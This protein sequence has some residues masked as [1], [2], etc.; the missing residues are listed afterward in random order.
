MGTLTALWLMLKRVPWKLWAFLALGAAFY[1]YGE[2]ND[3]S[4]H[5]EGA[6]EVQGR[7]DASIARG[8]EEIARLDRENAA[9]EAKARAEAIAIGESRRRDLQ[10]AIAERDR[11]I[12][13]LRS[14][15]IKLQDRWASCVSQAQAGDAADLSGGPLRQDELWREIAEQISES[16]D[17]D[18]RHARLVEFVQVLRK[19]C[20]AIQ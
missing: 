8:K 11:T 10:D 17:A 19:E 1:A 5:R 16:D 12:A 6:A 7:W 9:S 15:A 20:E 3:R 4:G 2:W 13:G 14:G 18:S